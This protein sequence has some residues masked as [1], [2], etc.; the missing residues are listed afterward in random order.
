MADQT[1]PMRI[2]GT[3]YAHSNLCRR[4]RDELV[5]AGISPDALVTPSPV[6]MAHV[7]FCG[8][9]SFEF[10]QHH[11]ASE[12]STAV[13]LVLVHDPSGT[14]LDIVA[15]DPCTGRLA[16]WLGR[17]WALGQGQIYAPRLSEHGALAVW[18]SPLEWLRQSR[19]GVVLIRPEGAA[20]HLDDAGPLMAEDVEHGLE[21][22]R[23]L[24]RPSPR[25]LV[26]RSDRRA[27]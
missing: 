13:L 5:H 2:Q 12:T 3:F 1:S 10:E 11:A 19:R 17:A 7:V 4:T 20:Y 15:F 8:A 16:T 23:V 18:R 26:R 22:R 14:A 25:I 24:T 6:L 27:A 21:L 9:H